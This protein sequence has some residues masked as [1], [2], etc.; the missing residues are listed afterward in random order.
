M[1]LTGTR[2]GNGHHDL[3][4]TVPGARYPTLDEPPVDQRL[5]ATTL[6]STLEQT[7]SNPR[8]GNKR[9]PEAM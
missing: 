1:T 5:E 8:H 9:N 2:S 6:G 3:A 7:Y 4:G